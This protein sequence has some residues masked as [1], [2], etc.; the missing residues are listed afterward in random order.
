MKGLFQGHAIV[1]AVLVLKRCTPCIV[2]D[3]GWVIQDV[4]GDLDEVDPA[5]CHNILNVMINI[6]VVS[7]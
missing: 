2:G 5:L 1:K 7:Q 6:C 4:L 3:D